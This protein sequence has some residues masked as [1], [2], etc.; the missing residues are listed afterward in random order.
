VIQPDSVADDLGGHCQPNRQQNEFAQ[1]PSV[2]RGISFALCILDAG[3]RARKLHRDAADDLKLTMPSC[4]LLQVN[5]TMP[6]HVFSLSLR[7]VE[8]ILAESSVV[9]SYETMRRFATI[10]RWSNGR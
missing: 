8:L 9:V 7:D 3:R 2:N 1:L 10:G 5:V 6:Y 4:R